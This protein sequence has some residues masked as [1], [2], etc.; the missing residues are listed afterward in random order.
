MLLILVAGQHRLLLHQMLD[1]DAEPLRQAASISRVGFQEVPN[2][3]FLNVLGRV[4]QTPD[5]IA[6]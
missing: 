6:D 1:I 5:D 3:F 4:A 2:L